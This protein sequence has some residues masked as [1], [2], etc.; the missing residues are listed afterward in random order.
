MPPTMTQPCQRAKSLT[1]STSC[2]LK[3]RCH[4][5]QM[6]RLQQLL[7]LLKKQVEYA[8]KQY[9]P[10]SQLEKGS[11]NLEASSNGSAY[12]KRMGQGRQPR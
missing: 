8:Y 6:L 1:T 9:E 4:L 5:N 10:K 2:A 7:L 3:L 12:I 11:N